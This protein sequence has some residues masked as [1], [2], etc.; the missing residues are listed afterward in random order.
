MNDEKKPVVS[1]NHIQEELSA[2]IKKLSSSLDL[3]IK[4]LRN[5]NKND[6]EEYSESEITMI[7]RC[8]FAGE[9][10]P[11]YPEKTSGIKI[12]NKK[13]I[14]NQNDTCLVLH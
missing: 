2:S 12:H 9:E 13:I 5:K 1:V 4:L 10:T 8:A 14:I 6:E 3:L 7:Q 11:V